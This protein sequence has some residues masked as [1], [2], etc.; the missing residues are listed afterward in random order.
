MDIRFDIETEEQV[1]VLR[2]S[3]RLVSSAI[4]QLTDICEP[5]EGGMVL[6]L[7]NLKFADD[8]SVGAIRTLAE[9]GAEIRGASSFIK[10]LINSDGKPGS[11]NQGF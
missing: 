8:A 1:V 11:K 3:G 5:I 9:E 4:R 10:L 2:I 7:S 6:D